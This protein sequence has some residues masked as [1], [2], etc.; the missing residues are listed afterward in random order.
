VL[1]TQAEKWDGKLPQ[2]LYASVPIPIINQ[3]H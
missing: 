1:Q 2:N 3:S